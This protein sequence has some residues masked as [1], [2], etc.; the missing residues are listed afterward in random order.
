MQDGRLG[1]IFTKFCEP[2][3]SNIYIYDPY[4]STKDISKLNT[5]DSLYSIAE[6][7]DVIILHIHANKET[8]EIINSF[9]LKKCKCNAI[10]VNTS[11]GEIINEENMINFLKNNPESKYLTDVISGES[12]DKTN[13][14]IYNSFLSGIL[15]NQLIITPHIGGVTHDARDIAYNHAANLL[16][17]HV[18]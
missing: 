5:V 18:F 15:G 14:P 3:N 10:I 13:S 6:I 8:K 11:R 7:C 4:V 1:K 17:N 2:F 16:I 9:F 12:I